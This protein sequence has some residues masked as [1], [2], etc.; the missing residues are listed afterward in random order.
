VD[1]TTVRHDYFFLNH[2][3]VLEVYLGDFES[4]S[5]SLAS[6]GDLTYK[7]IEL[8]KDNVFFVLSGRYGLRNKKVVN[9][10]DKEQIYVD[11]KFSRNISQKMDSS[12]VCDLLTQ[13]KEDSKRTTNRQVEYHFVDGKTSAKGM[14]RNGKPHGLWKYYYKNGN[15]AKTKLYE[16][17]ELIREVDSYYKN[18]QVKI[19]FKK[20]GKYVHRSKYYESGILNSVSIIDTINSSLI[21]NS[22]KFYYEN[23]QLKKSSTYYSR[24]PDPRVVFYYEGLCTEYDN[25]GKVIS[26]GKFHLGSK[27]GK[28]KEF[29]KKDNEVSKVKYTK[30]KN[31]KD[32]KTRVYFST[33]QLHD[34]GVLDDKGR[35]QGIW[36]TYSLNGNLR[37]ITPFKDGVIDGVSEKYDEGNKVGHTTYINGKKDGSYRDRN[38]GRKIYRNKKIISSGN[39]KDYHRIGVWVSKIKNQI[40]ERAF[41]NE[42]GKLHGE[43]FQFENETSVL[44]ANY[45][46]GLLQGDYQLYYPDGTI[47]ETGQYDK[48]YMVGEWV[49]YNI[50]GSEYARCIQSLPTTKLFYNEECGYFHHRDK[51][52]LDNFSNANNKPEPWD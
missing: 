17:G 15:V 5:V 21:R 9:I 14:I 25:T 6:N 43:F 3:E 40:V 47:K 37:L 41:Y 2:G 13:Y 26:K 34:V 20:K 24:I 19:K 28:W 51:V 42:K 1:T 30:I 36:K 50:D 10:K 7:A 23:G 32:G 29:N 33:G 49:A 22:D 39:Y 27:V 16:K 44:A 12:Y 4:S 11:W 38:Y 35:K 48:G 18:G 52:M 46:N 8:K 45:E 31:I